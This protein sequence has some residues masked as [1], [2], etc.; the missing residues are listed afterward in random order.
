MVVSHKERRRRVY[1][2]AQSRGSC[3]WIFS[4][5]VNTQGWLVVIFFLALAWSVLFR[6][7]FDKKVKKGF[8]MKT[9]RSWLIEQTFWSKKENKCTV[10][11]QI[12]SVLLQIK[13]NLLRMNFKGK[14]P[15]PFHVERLIK[16]NNAHRLKNTLYF[17]LGCFLL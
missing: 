5:V 15:I 10:L 8:Q 4:E 16:H 3:Q 17:I 6:A 13:S 2:L 14:E 11:G 1:D 7:Q 12:P 9:K